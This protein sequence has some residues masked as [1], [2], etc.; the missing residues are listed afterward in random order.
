MRTLSEAT[1]QFTTTELLSALWY[2]DGSGARTSVDIQG[3]PDD[4]AIASIYYDDTSGKIT[5]RIFDVYDAED[6][7]DE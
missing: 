3:G 4:W 5:I 1:L 2:S 6:S 7:G